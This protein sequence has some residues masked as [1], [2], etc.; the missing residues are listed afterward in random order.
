MFFQRVK[1]FCI[2]YRRWVNLLGAFLGLCVIIY[3][4]PKFESELTKIYKSATL[5]GVISTL[6][7]AV[8]G[9]IFTLIGSI[10]VSKHQQKA[11]TQ[12]RRKN[13]IY[14]PIY[15]E[16]L[17]NHS[18]FSPKEPYTGIIVVG[19]NYYGYR[20]IPQYSAWN[21]IKSDSRRL[22]VPPN[23][24]KEL[25]VLETLIKKYDDQRHAAS[26]SIEKNLNTALSTEAQ[27]HCTI[28]NSG[29]VLIG[30]VLAQKEFDLFQELVFAV[31]PKIEDKQ[32]QKEIQELFLRK[33]KYDQSV[34][35]VYNYYDEWK[36]QEEKVIT[37]LELTIRQISMRYE[38]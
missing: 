11:Q 2:R 20:N 33:C 21:R 17:K 13:V 27:A 38:E 9:G 34:C 37:L 24:A 12:I 23:L 18:E 30:F 7:G 36:T 1:L 14:K 16:L 3:I 29:D 31:T 15:D 28:Q 5:V 19:E 25:D 26:V 10:S 22:E 32:K 6:L 8:V 35:L 4:M